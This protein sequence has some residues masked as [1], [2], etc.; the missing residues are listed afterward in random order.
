MAAVA[1]AWLAPI[2]A[3]HAILDETVAAQGLIAPR[4]GLIRV[5]APAGATGQP[6]VRELRVAE[7]DV[8]EPG[9]VL[10]VLATQPAA[11]AALLAARREAE[12]A[13]RGVAI[14]EA[15][16]AAARAEADAAQGE[17]EPAKAQVAAAEA[18]VAEAEA[19]VA[20]AEAQWRT[21]QKSRIEALEKL[22]A[23]MA[24]IT[25][26]RSAYQDQLDRF[27]PP[28]REAEEIKLRQRLLNEE[29]RKLSGSRNGTVARLDAEIAAAE[30]AVES[31]RTALASARAQVAIARARVAAAELGVEP[32]RARVAVV[33]AEL[34][35]ARAA[36]E[37]ADAGVARARAQLAQSEVRA[38]SAGT[39]LHVGARPGEAVGPQGLV[40]LGDLTELIV[41]AEIYIDDVRKVKA[42]QKATLESDAFEG[43]L[44]GVVESVG[45]LV[46][47][48]GLFSNDPLA[49]TDQRVV[50]ARIRLTNT[51]IQGWTPPIHSQV[52]ARIKL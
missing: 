25:G 20:Q 38:P 45:R 42:G 13:Q 37:T 23:A 47:P 1:A 27:D 22:D 24:H 39:V 21:A 12:A 19:G 16:L 32:A 35:R 34:E 50:E 44:E 11:E 41:R 51:E 10:G 7:G 6:I 28:R 3:S 14:V 18:G 29:L 52:V 40:I 17:L 48:Q 31:A 5:A 15:Q 4:D 36:A 8:V 9:A 30:A 43:K 46:N 49:Y 26:S 33:E 2:A